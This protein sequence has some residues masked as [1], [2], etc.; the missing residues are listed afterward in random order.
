MKR[1]F[2]TLMITFNLI[3]VNAQEMRQLWIEMPDSIVP[4][5][6]KSLRTELADY[7]TMKMKPE[8]VNSLQDTTRIEKFT[9]NYIRVQ[10]NNA[11]KLEI[12][13]LDNSTIALVQ[14]WNG[15]IAESKLMLFSKEWKL[16]PFE[17]DLTPVFEK[18]DSML[19]QRYEDLLS[20]AN[21]T[22][23]EFKLS[24]SDNSLTIK[25]TV[26]LLSSNDKT[27]MSNILKQRKL[28]WNGAFFK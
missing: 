15:P 2:L 6:N 18:S 23:C 19:Q 21:I 3:A 13:S 16:K 27:D 10:L 1:I 14:T 12:K 26:P 17:I 7:V 8:V 9:N 20:M 24:E 28:N 4:Y 5:L 22:L 25:F 11:S